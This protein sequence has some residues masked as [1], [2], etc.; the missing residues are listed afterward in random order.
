MLYNCS[1]PKTPLIKFEMP[2]I[3]L[4]VSFFPCCLQ[5]QPM[6]RRRKS[7]LLSLRLFLYRIPQ[8][9]TRNRKDSTVWAI[10]GVI[11]LTFARE[12]PGDN[13]SELKQLLRLSRFL[14]LSQ[15][16]CLLRVFLL[17]WVVG[18]VCLLLRHCLTL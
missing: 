8:R 9:L 12:I 2:C 18:C 16:F 1:K 11:S 6:T 13:L 14:L 3:L 15:V 17:V 5:H 7:F 4:R 10:L